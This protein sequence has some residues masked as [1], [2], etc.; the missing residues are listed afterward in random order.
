MNYKE[1]METFYSQ[2]VPSITWNSVFA[3]S[4]NFSFYLLLSLDKNFPF[5]GV[6]ALRVKPPLE[7]SYAIV[8]CFGVESV[9]F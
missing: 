4:D 6:V 8:E 9:C 2:Y 3:K 7:T 5:K 1:K